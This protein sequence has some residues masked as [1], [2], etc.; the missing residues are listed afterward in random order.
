LSALVLVG[1]VAPV[2][3]LAT[4][5]AGGRTVAEVVSGGRLLG[6]ITAADLARAAGQGERPRAVA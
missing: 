1:P 2:A 3:D 5:L 4:R 6:L